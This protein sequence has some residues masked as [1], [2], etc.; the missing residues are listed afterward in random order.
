M[1]DLGFNK[2]AGAVLATGLAIVGLKELTSVI[3]KVEPVEKP[4]YAITVAEE[5]GEGGAAAVE[6]AIDWGTVL[7]TADIAAGEAV[8][9]K[10]ASC[11]SFN[12]G[13]ANMVGPNLYGVVGMKPGSHA[14]MAYSDG[15]KEF[16]SKT[17]AWGYEQLNGFLTAPQKYIAG[18]KMS[19]VGLKKPEDRINMIAYLHSLG[20]TLQ[21]P[22]PAPAAAAP[23]ADAA[24][25]PAAAPAPA[26]A[27][28]PAA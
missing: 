3:Y 10:C 14:G 9:K 7:P 28:K 13:G 6:V 19:F 16:G 18:T 24:A 21:I 27:A 26:P 25:A 8:A 17:P 23:A 20:S 4:G 12:Q 15:L 5:A 22:A 1:S 11:H 2:I